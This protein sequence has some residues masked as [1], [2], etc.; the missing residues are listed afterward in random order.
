[1]SDS[2]SAEDR[3]IPITK[4]D[5][6]N[7]SMPLKLHLGELRRRLLRVIVAT[8]AGFIVCYPF[9]EAI[10]DHLTAPWMQQGDD[11]V[12]IFTGPVEVFIAYLKISF[13]FGLVLAAPYAVIQL[14]RFIEPGLK[15]KEKR[16]FIPFTLLVTLFFVGGVLFAYIV[17]LPVAFEFFVSFAPEF[18]EA[19]LRVAE[20]VQFTLKLLLAFGLIFLVPL[21]LV[22][23][24]Y[25]GLMKT[26]QIARHWRVVVVVVCV[27]SALLTPADPLTMMLM[28]VPLLTLFTI[29][30]VLALVVERLT[31]RG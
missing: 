11:V 6:I 28:A 30:L 19:K 22:L 18:V 5:D 17:V 15:K 20:Y 2:E 12:L 26:A 3:S 9:A 4:E 8:V 14:W 23:I 16:F 21:L 25:L 7:E 27:M 29:S 13:V 1:M 10:F 31:K 24:V